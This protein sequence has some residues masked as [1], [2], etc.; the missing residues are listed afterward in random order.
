MIDTL[1]TFADQVTTVAREVGV[2]GKLGGQAN[3]PGASGT[4]KDLTENVNQLAQNLTTQV[5][6][7]SEVASDVKKGDITRM[8]RV[9][10]KGEVEEL[11]D[12]INQMIANLKETTL[13]NQEQDWLKSNLAKFTQML[14]GQKDLNTV[15]RRI[16]SEL[17]QVVNAQKG[18]FYILEQDENF[19]NQK[20]KL[21]AAYAFGEEVKMAKEL[22]LGEGLVGQVAIEKERILLT[23]V[24]K[25]YIK[26]SSGLGEAT[27]ASVI[28]LPVLFETEIKAVIE[29][30]SFDQFSET[31]LDFL[32]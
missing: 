16:L 21:F 28:V 1:A 11:K 18:M 14:Q 32:S 26:I 23:N 31:H 20:L 22:E 15:T 3:V 13:R 2:E 6:S 27:P 29:L 4:W 10:A 5:R 7:I 17:A 8:I 19:Q 24:P 9:E 12:T 25:D 30:A